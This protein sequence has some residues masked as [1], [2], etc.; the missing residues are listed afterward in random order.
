M[1]DHV[2]FFFSLP[3]AVPPYHTLYTKSQDPLRKQ[4][5]YTTYE[6]KF[7]NRVLSSATYRHQRL[8]WHLL[9]AVSALP[10]NYCPSLIA[11]AIN[12]YIILIS[13]WTKT[14]GL[15]QQPVCLKVLDVQWRCLVLLL[16]HLAYNINEAYRWETCSTQ[17]WLQLASQIHPTD[18][19]VP[20]P[21]L[22][23]D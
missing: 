8:I 18:C 14:K 7:S 5:A 21:V 15:T 10:R 23:E 19:R 12:P 3:L 11:N 2:R 1:E 20:T 13:N 22:I 17:A 16:L 6:C 4:T 9:W